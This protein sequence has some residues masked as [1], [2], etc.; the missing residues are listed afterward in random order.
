MKQCVINVGMGGWF[1]TGTQRLKE[2]FVEYGYTG[3]FL[4]WID[5]DGWPQGLS[6]ADCPYGF[7]AM[8]FMEARNM[9]YTHILWCD[10]SIWAMRSVVPLFDYIDHHGYL[11]WNSGWNCGEW[12]K[13]DALEP[14]G[15]IRD[16]LFH[17][18]QIQASV[19]GLNFRHQVANEFLSNWVDFAKDGVTFPGPW[20]ND[21]NEASTDPRVRGHRHD[22]LAASVIAHRL[23]MGMVDSPK[24]FIY[25][26]EPP[27]DDETILLSRG[28]AF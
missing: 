24:F 20:T 26:Q 15:V 23:N 17:M 6:H 14:L 16:E 28:G 18:R 27:Y 12:C 1:P 10:S 7:K 22:Q 21:N 8:A 11:L 19:L 2:S 4:T 3:D 25:W 9:G 5:K 13:D